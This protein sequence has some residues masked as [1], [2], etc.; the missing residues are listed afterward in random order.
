MQMLFWL[1]TQ[2][3]SATKVG[4]EDC[5]ISSKDIFVGSYVAWVPLIKKEQNNLLELM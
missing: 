3:S 1:V 4:K 5:V 2:S